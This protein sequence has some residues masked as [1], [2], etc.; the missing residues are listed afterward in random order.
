MAKAR[1]LPEHFAVLGISRDRLNDRQFRDEVASELEKQVNKS[2]FDSGLAHDLIRRFHYL[3]GDLT[4]LHENPQLVSELRRLDE[5]SQTQ[6]NILF[7]LATPPALFGEVVSALGKLGLTS[8]DHG[9]RRVV[10]EKP[11]GHDLESARSLNQS[12]SRVL[13]EGQIFRIDHYLGKETVQNIL[14][15]RFA[16]GIYEPIWNRRYI[17]S[18]QITVAETLGVENRAGYY[19]HAGA[20]RDMVSSHLLQLLSL[21][22]MEPPASFRADDVRDEKVKALKAIKPLTQDGVMHQAIRGQYDQGQIDS[23][24]IPAYRF[25][26]GV[27]RYSATETF[28]AIKF[29]L[30]NWR[31]AGVPFYLRVGK[32]LPKRYT[33]IAI[34]FKCAPFQLFRETHTGEL[35]PN[36]LVMHIQPEEGIEV[37]FT[38]K[39]PGS[40]IRLVGVRMSFD[41]ADYFG[42]TPSTG[43][44]TLLHDCMNGDGTLFRRADQVEQSWQAIMP[45]LDVWNA[46]RPEDFPNYRSGTWGPGS[47]DELLAR[48]GRR[49]RQISEGDR[50]PKKWRRSA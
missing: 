18:V 47:A 4:K 45:I 9:W 49:W 5:T 29:E 40:S 7:Y 43:Y 32:R 22:A 8:E 42:K 50:A 15:F 30:E 16:N 48:D 37:S 26:P 23:E 31:W 33:E 1:L 3:Q 34:Q 11:F 28:A 24:V 10:I 17:D 20:L 44:E 46:L 19:E 6:G 13:Q 41:Y 35:P 25:E 27:S 14:V 36:Y 2:E 39:I 38:G 21:V 12:L